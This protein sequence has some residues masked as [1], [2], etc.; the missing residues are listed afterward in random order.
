MVSRHRTVYHAAC[1][2]VVDVGDDEEDD[3]EQN[4]QDE[5]EDDDED[6]EEDDS[7]SEDS[8]S[9]EEETDE[10]VN[11]STYHPAN[12]SSNANA[13]TSPGLPTFAW[14]PPQ[15][16]SSENICKWPPVYS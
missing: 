4:D 9:D 3:D 1:L 10:E 2:T 8:E 15:P 7:G 5:E 11:A 14:R 12:G 6:D 13:G 16:P